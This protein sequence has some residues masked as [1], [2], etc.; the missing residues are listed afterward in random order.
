M[1]TEIALSQQRL[2]HKVVVMCRIAA[3]C[4]YYIYWR[5]SFLMCELV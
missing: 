1:H 5:Y 4:N 3:N 2:S